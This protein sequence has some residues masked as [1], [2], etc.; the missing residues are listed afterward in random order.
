MMHKPHLKN[1]LGLVLLGL[2]F[3][4]PFLGGVHL[5]DWDEINFAEISREMIV[6]ND[7][8]RVHVD[9]L[10]FWEK[11]PLFFWLQV[12]SMKLWGINEFAA[13][14]PNAICGILTLVLLYLMGKRLWNARFGFIWALAYFGSVLP[15]LYFKSGIID[16][17]FNL[18]I[19]GGIYVFILGTWKRTKISSIQIARTPWYYFLVGGLLIGLGILTKG[20]VAYLIAGLT[21]GVYWILKRFR[22]FVSVPQFLMFTVAATLAM[23][24]WYGIETWKNGPWFINEFNRYQYRLF[25]TP[26]AGHRGFPGYHFV[27][28]LVGCFPAS[29][30]CLDE[31]FKPIKLKEAHLKDFRTWMIV[32]MSV[33]VVLFSIVQSK[34]VHYSSMAYFPLSFLAALSMYHWMTYWRKFSR[35]MKIGLYGIGGL[36]AFATLVMPWVGRNV[37]LLI[38]LIKDPFAQAN[39]QAEVAWMGWESLVAVIMIGS[40]I[41]G[42]YFMKTH[43][44]EVGFKFL[45][46]GTAVFVFATLIFFI[47]K[48][49]TYSQRAAIEHMKSLQGKDIYINTHGYKSYAKLFYTQKPGRTNPKD[50]DKFWMFR[51]RR[52]Q[53]CACYL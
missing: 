36:Y 28:I 45:F 12:L 43:E 13:R 53:R 21:F 18:F 1:L 44:A 19:F 33:V 15:H 25:S 27:V 5:F 47:G 46:G 16:P 23:A 35:W 14:F 7:Y 50:G 49:E 32:L 39:L 38:P 17:W 48:I 30:F 6:L 42:T 24:T 11:P 8:L 22:M 20:P 9:F 10:P 31:L 26:D 4:V 37:D 51:G 40:L 52:R 29:I 2:V 34:I 3:F 41:L